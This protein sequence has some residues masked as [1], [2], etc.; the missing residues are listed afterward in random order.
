MATV[1]RENIGEG[2]GLTNL[3]RNLG[4]SVGIS[5][6]TALVSRG[7]QTHQALMVG[8][9][10]QYNPVFNAQFAKMQTAL[11]PQVGSSAA[12]HQAYGLTYQTLQQQASLWSYLDVFR[13]L[14]IVCL[15][16]VPLVFLFKKPKR[17]V[18][19]GE[20]AAAH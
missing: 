4:G 16:C 10:S 5:G 2:T 14:V 19:P 17:P 6:I 8:H 11:T 13:M 15:A 1:S 3:L 7:A 18:V 20:L 12:H 9:T